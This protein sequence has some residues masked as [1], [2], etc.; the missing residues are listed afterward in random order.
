MSGSG[1]S[2]VPL[3][4]LTV[5]VPATLSLFV[6]SPQ[7]CPLARAEVP[8]MQLQVQ[9]RAPLGLLGPPRVRSAGPSLRGRRPPLL[10]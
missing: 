6:S 5:Y 9:P 3:V 7:A 4:D 8:G 10:H 2:P 1:P